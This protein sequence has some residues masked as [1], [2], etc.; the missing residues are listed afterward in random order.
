MWGS[1]SL[2]LTH[3]DRVFLFR[4]S[5]V[6]WWDWEALGGSDLLLVAGQLFSVSTL[7]LLV[8]SFDL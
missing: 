4:G 7:M 1:V 5:L 3:C 6:T 8:G 2:G